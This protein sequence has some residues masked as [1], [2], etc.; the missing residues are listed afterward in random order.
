MGEKGQDQQA[1]IPQFFNFIGSNVKNSSAGNGTRT[2]Q[3]E[4]A[5]KESPKAFLQRYEA[6]QKAQEKID[7]ESR[8]RFKEL[9]DT[10]QVFTGPLYKQDGD[11]DAE[12]I[13]LVTTSTSS[14]QRSHPTIGETTISTREGEKIKADV[15]AVMHEQFAEARAALRADLGLPKK[16][17]ENSGKAAPAKS[18]IDLVSPSTESVGTPVPRSSFGSPLSVGTVNPSAST[19]HS[20][21]QPFGTVA[22]KPKEPPCFFGRSTEEAHT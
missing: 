11:N 3:T 2:I 13:D 17:T 12:E 18:A 20:H 19:V 4:P 21:H 16:V 10:P 14:Q 5:G 15:Q 9:M 8:R 7:E 1:K 6:E 22:W